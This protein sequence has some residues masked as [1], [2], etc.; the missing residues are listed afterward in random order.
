MA[1]ATDDLSIPVC[2]LTLRLQLRKAGLRLDR[3]GYGYEILFKNQVLF[4]GD[5]HG[6]GLSLDEIAVFCE[7][8]LVR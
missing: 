2:E 6:E 8:A 1:K 4:S 5:V 7:R 3:R